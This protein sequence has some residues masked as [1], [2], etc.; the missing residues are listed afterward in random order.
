MYRWSFCWESETVIAEQSG[1]GPHNETPII[2]CHNSS[3]GSNW[4]VGELQATQLVSV[5]VVPFTEAC[6]PVAD[7][8]LVRMVVAF[9]SP[10][11]RN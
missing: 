5:S 11:G 10:V 6:L 9:V 2:G 7:W 4:I 8:I 1:H 3:G